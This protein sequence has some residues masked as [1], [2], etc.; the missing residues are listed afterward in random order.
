MKYAL[1]AMAVMFALIVWP[2]SWVWYLPL[3]GI[4]G[5]GVSESFL[6]PIYGG[7]ILLSGLIVFCTN[8]ILDE[9]R[10]LRD[11]IKGKDENKD[12]EP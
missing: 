3:S 7:L 9:V 4:L 5:G 12:G 10:S 11:E 2:L 6:Y 8:R 1:A